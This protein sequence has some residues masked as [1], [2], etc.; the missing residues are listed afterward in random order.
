MPSFLTM[1]ETLSI[2]CTALLTARQFVTV[3]LTAFTVLCF[4]DVSAE[5]TLAYIW[6]E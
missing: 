6:H 4:S 5:H 3:F 1:K 2:F